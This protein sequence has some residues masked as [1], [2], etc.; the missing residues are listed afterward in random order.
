MKPQIHATA[1]FL[2]DVGRAG[3]IYE[4]HQIDALIEYLNSLGTVR[5]D[6]HYD[7]WHDLYERMPYHG[8]RNI[9]AYAVEKAHAAGIEVHAVFK[10]FELGAFNHYYLPHAFPRP[11]G[12]PTH[13]DRKG[14][15]AMVDPFVVDHP[16]LRIKRLA[17]D[18]NPP[19]NVT[20]IKLVKADDAPT[21]VKAEHLSVWTSSRN[22]ELYRYEEPWSLDERIEQRDGKA[23]R[24]F[25]ISGLAIDESTPY[26][27]VKCD[28]R[29]GHGSFSNT[30]H[31]IMEIYAGDRMLPAVSADEKITMAKLKG[32]VFTR[33][34][35]IFPIMRAATRYGQAPEVLEFARDKQRIEALYDNFFRFDYL[36]EQEVDKLPPD[37]KDDFTPY[38]DRDH[39]VMSGFAGVVRGKDEHYA[40][41][42]H[43]VYPDVRHYWLDVTRRCLA[44]GVD[45]VSYRVNNHNRMGEP[46][47]YG[48]NDPVLEMTNGN[49]DPAVVQKVNGDAYT[50]FLREARDLLHA[51]DKVI[52]IQIANDKHQ[53]HNHAPWNFE[54]QW[55]RWIEEDLAD[56]VYTHIRATS[57]SEEE[58]TS[59]TD[60]V[61]ALAKKHDKP[62]I[63]KCGVS[64]EAVE[65]TLALAEKNPNIDA[66]NLYETGNFTRLREDGSFEGDAEVARVIHSRT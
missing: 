36:P 46:E 50:Q 47:L 8:R 11:E 64:P 18:W 48:F 66:I 44:C 62:V 41:V 49:T 23:H 30:I 53:K 63:L 1:D 55:D 60:R 16:T 12:I 54:W 20:T 17:G 5:L 52:T 13:A 2:D 14:L 6:W 43:P 32:H 59:F 21:D 31:R 29:T 3:G 24:V 34:E 15:F 27:F 56:V 25:D 9:L 4:P 45:G 19:G 26:I 58:A 39:G 38:L 57:W 51:E 28:L 42:M 65:Q 7:T 10:P 40:S 35:P 33:G 22:G 61:M 37:V